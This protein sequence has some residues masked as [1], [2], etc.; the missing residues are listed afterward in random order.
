[1]W[2]KFDLGH[3]EEE[4]SL[5]LKHQRAHQV[6]TYKGSVYLGEVLL[7]RL[8][9][10]KVISIKVEGL[11]RAPQMGFVVSRTGRQRRLH[12]FVGTRTTA[13]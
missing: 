2:Y 8:S 10:V 1:M 11:N 12:N 5:E 4:E 9:E 6:L 7:E 3:L 13:H